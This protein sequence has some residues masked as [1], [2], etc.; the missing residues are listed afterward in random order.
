MLEKVLRCIVSP[1]QRTGIQLVQLT[2]KFG[3]INLA[4]RQFLL[5]GNQIQLTCKLGQINLAIRNYF[6]VAPNIINLIIMHCKSGN[7]V[8]LTCEI[9]TTL[10]SN[11]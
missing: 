11:Q 2:C 6:L 4:V 8:K 1:W 5:V 9:C 10:A 3:E 7:Q